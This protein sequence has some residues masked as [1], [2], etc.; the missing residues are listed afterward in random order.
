M[1]PV[2]QPP[3]ATAIEGLLVIVTGHLEREN[4]L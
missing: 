2:Y 4:T 3:F 1:T